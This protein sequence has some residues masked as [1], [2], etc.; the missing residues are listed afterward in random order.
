MRKTLFNHFN[1]SMASRMGSSCISR[2]VTPFYLLLF[3]SIVFIF[4]GCDIQIGDGRKKKGD[5]DTEK[6]V[7]P[8]VV[9]QSWNGDIST[10]LRLN[11]ILKTDREV[12]VFSRSVGRIVGLSVEE[13]SWVQA[14]QLLARL[15]D[16]EQKLAVER[17]QTSFEMDRA[18]LDRAEKL[19]NQNMMAEDEYERIKLSL[20]DARLRLKQA[21]LNYEH[22][23]ITAPFSGIIAER[24]VNFGDRIDI[25]RP[26]FKL[27]NS[28]KLRIDGWVAEVNISK[29]R[30]GQEASISSAAFPD[31]RFI[32]ELVR[33]SP[34]V[35]PSYGKVKVTFEIP[36]QDG[37]L[38]PGQFVELSLTLETHRNVR[39]IPKKAVVYEA[40]IPVVFINQDSLAFRRTIDI[41]LQT[42][43][44]V[45]ILSGIDLGA[46]VIVDGQSTLRDSSLVKVVPP[47]R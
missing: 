14:G 22:T 8:V 42:G 26:L 24:Y 41:G 40:G 37:R 44:I 17:A 32:A 29:L 47:A 27:V 43:D 28:S 36:N 46:G 10:Y 21:E 18:S 5:K 25:S 30:I 11:G 4:S 20:D 38:K 35:D 45:E 33:I 6:A 1:I 15:E 3:S 39:L 34:I 7:A 16:D 2:T 19:F 13:G 23:R 9:T 31:D 12:Q